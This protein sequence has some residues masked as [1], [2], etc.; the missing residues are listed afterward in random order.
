MKFTTPPSP[1]IL[2]HSATAAAG[3]F[4]PSPANANGTDTPPT[5]EKTTSAERAAR[6]RNRRRRA[7]R[8]LESMLQESQGHP[9]RSLNDCPQLSRCRVCSATVCS[10]GGILRGGGDN[11]R[12]GS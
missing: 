4:E 2:A 7:E 5:I 10:S 12:G 9:E 11:A 3:L 6:T 8:S 1:C